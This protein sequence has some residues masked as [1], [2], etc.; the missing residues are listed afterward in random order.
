MFSFVLLGKGVLKELFRVRWLCEN[1]ERTKENMDTTLAGE[2][3]FSPQKHTYLPA[4]S[5]LERTKENI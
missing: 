1:V 2:L 3:F 4:Y 5:F